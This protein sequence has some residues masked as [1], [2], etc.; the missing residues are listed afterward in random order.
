M[1][2]IIP[3]IKRIRGSIKST[4]VGG[5]LMTFGGYLLYNSEDA[6]MIG[7]STSIIIVGLV[8]L[9]L[10]DYQIGLSKKKDNERKTS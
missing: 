1:K 5:L 4:I 2:E 6:L 3:Y 10:E 8:L 9:F 7:T